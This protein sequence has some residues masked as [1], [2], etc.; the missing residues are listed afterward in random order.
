MS[1]FVTRL[2]SMPDTG[3]SAFLPSC[4]HVLAGLMLAALLSAQGAEASRGDSAKAARFHADAVARLARNDL[5]GAIIQARN[6]VQQ[7]QGLLAAHML[8]GRAL[9]RDGQAAAAEAEFEIALQQGASMAEVA[10]PYGTALMMFGNS[11]KLLARIRPDGL[12]PAVRAEVLAMRA[13]AHADQGDMKAAFRTVEEARA[14]DRRSLAP[15]RT[16]IDLALRGRDTARAG[17]ALDAAVALAPRDPQLLHLQGV[18]QQ[19]A[20]NSAAALDFFAQALKADPRLLDA[21]V[22]RASLL[23]DLRRPQEAMP[24]LERAAGLSQRE[25][26]VAYLKSLIYAARGDTKASRA[27]LE[28]V[29]RLVDALPDT[30]I[31]HQPPLLM[32]GGLASQ[33]TGRLER[34]RALLEQYVLR[35]PDDPAGRKLLASI[36][37]SSGETARVADLLDPL[38]RSDSADPQVLTT[39]AALRMQQRRYR[40]AAEALEKA[41][42]MTGGDPGITAQMGFARL[43]NQQADLGLAA[44]RAAFDKEPGQLK[45]ASALVTLYLRRGDVRNATAV[46]DALLRRLPNEAAAH[47]LAGAV[48]GAARQPAEARAA[49]LKALA[50]QPGLV[51]AR[52]NLARLDAAEGRFDAARQRLEA[53]LKDAPGNG[54]ALTE[55]ARLEVQAG[56]LDAARQLLEKAQ[57]A[58]PGEMA[59]GL[60]LLAVH[61]RLGQPGAAL[62][63]ARQLIAQRPDDP[64]VIEALGRAQMA[65]GDGVQARATFANLARMAGPDPRY[66]VA[67]GQL[68]L[69][70][71][72]ANDAGA[73][74]EKALAM[75]PGFMPALVLQVEAEILAGNLPRAETLQRQLAARGR[76]ADS[77][78][79]EGDIALARR[80]PRDAARLYQAAFDLTP[81]PVLAQRA[82]RAAFEAGQGERGLAVLERWLQ[83]HP[84]DL[85]AQEALAE[86]YLRQGRLALARTA[87]EVLLARD[88]HNPVAA[89]NLAQ[90]LMRL[91]DRG[92]LEM[93][94]RAVRLAP[95]SGDALDTLGWIQARSGAFDAALKTLREARLRMPESR[96]LR[97]HLAWALYRSGRRDEARDELASAL[98]ARGNGMEFENPAEV[99]VLRRELGV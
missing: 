14:A 83:T 29:L 39:L 78:R 13:T 23:I 74:A 1:F 81:S 99:E 52:L 82:F 72:A 2:P 34:A 32:L 12:P 26:R 6:A 17:R 38:L 98:K 70:A 75:K 18:M 87:Y 46:A 96:E 90:V 51:P 33:A 42:R 84:D 58:Q 88:Q 59:S 68:Q 66:L 92:A 35:M 54:Q 61:R 91:D 37:L 27:Q 97:Y 15:L 55:L 79:L 28:E 16:E 25:P 11:E 89:N 85:Q 73:S 50:L 8:L 22:A 44:L 3:H 65:V 62:A 20:G 48:R 31:A 36:Y 76:N 60:E 95:A 41:A 43:A 30:F 56:R 5:A 63:L 94:E 93:A 69:T 80:N 24:D 45:V 9:L 86:G 10:L 7:D 53:L 64:V 19:A 71:G 40:E 4:R 21:L 67:V 57:A 47:N 49:Y 77:L